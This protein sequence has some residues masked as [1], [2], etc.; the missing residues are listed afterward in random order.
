MIVTVYELSAF[1]ELADFS[2]GIYYTWSSRNIGNLLPKVKVETKLYGV[3]KDGSLVVLDRVAMVSENQSR[4]DLSLEAG[5]R[6]VVGEIVRTFEGEAVRLAEANQSKAVPG[7]L[8]PSPLNSHL[9]SM[10]TVR[11]EAI[12]GRLLRLEEKVLPP[13]MSQGSG[14]ADHES[15]ISRLEKVIVGS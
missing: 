5:I 15:R 9:S 8:K 10:L 11:L 13:L 1:E 7:D 14:A 3:G 12:E 6:L 2:K 4:P